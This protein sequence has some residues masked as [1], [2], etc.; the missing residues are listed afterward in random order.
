VILQARCPIFD[1]VKNKESKEEET[2][3]SVSLLL[4]AGL[5]YQKVFRSFGFGIKAVVK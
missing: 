2:D 5:P 4:N 3:P 1:A